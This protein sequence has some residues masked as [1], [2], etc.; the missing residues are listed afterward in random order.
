MSLEALLANMK[1]YTSKLHEL[2]GFRGAVT[3]SRNLVRVMDGSDLLT[4]RLKV[5]VQ[6]AYSMRSTP[7]VIGA[8]HDAWEFA[9]SQGGFLR[10]KTEFFESPAQATHLEAWSSDRCH[11]IGH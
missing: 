1:P 11:Q 3:T 4:G 7:Q 9:R 8:A 10:V 5:K 2:R 6:D